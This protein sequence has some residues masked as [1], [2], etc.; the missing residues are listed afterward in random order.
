MTGDVPMQPLAV[1][2]GGTRGIGLALSLRLLKRGHRVV[3]LYRSHES[4]ARS[5][6][7]E[8]GPGFAAVRVDVADS[9]AVREFASRLLTG[10]GA[11]GCW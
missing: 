8:L 3:A 7:A 1:V 9:A 6:G 10:H 11:P 2:S 5:A 4:A